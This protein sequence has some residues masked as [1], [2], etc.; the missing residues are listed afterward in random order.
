H[1]DDHRAQLFGGQPLDPAQPYRFGYQDRV[2][3]VY[4]CRK[5]ALVR[6]LVLLQEACLGEDP[7]QPA[8]LA[9][10]LV[11]LA[12]GLALPAV[13]L[14]LQGANLA[15]A[16]QQLAEPRRANH[17]E[18]A[19][20]VE[21]ALGLDLQPLRDALGAAHGPRAA[22]AAPSALRACLAPEPLQLDPDG[23]SP[24]LDLEV[25]RHVLERDLGVVPHAPGVR[26]LFPDIG[27]P[28]AGVR[29]RE[30]LLEL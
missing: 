17:F 19:L 16:L 29:G 27:Q 20:P 18:L 21:Q 2:L 6:R 28:L 12:R 11:H 30:A 24:F 4:A 22:T 14:L 23:S 26:E 10:V 25:L 3:A 5:E 8:K 13:Q 15:V 7:R 9:R 1:H